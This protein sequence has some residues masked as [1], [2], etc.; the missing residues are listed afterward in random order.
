[1]LTVDNT[2]A[3][4]GMGCI[5][6]AGRNIADIVE[7]I[8]SGTRSPVISQRIHVNHP[9]KYP[10]FEM[11]ETVVP[12]GYYEAP[13]ASRCGILAI[14]ALQQALFAA[15]LDSK[16]LRNFRL[17]ICI[18]STVGN[19][20]NNEKFFADFLNSDYPDMEA[21]NDYLHASPA[22]M[23]AKYLGLN[24]LRQSVSNACASGAVAI[25]QGAKWLQNGLCDIVIAGGVDI[26]CRVI[27]N[28]FV[29]LKITDTEF[30]RPFDKNRAGLNLGE[31][32]GIVILET[33]QHARRRNS[34]NAGYVCGYGNFSDAYHMSAP[35]PDGMGLRYAID[36][37]LAQSSLSYDQITFINAH[38]TATSENDKVEGRLI[39]E[40]LPSVPFQSTKGYTGHT[41]GAAG[42]IEAILTIEQLNRQIMAASAGFNEPDDAFKAN[43]VIC[44]TTISGDYALSNSLAFGGNNAVLLLKRGS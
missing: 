37:A 35:V 34:I 5:C 20:M 6:A 39:S 38:G 33:I 9:Q 15:G 24:C 30:C 16:Q 14:E 7:A 8:Y 31:G 36:T 12:A 25:G 23:I 18:G 42:A 27:Y 44:N 13:E 29:S 1:M 41:L 26:L 28:G 43:P 40:L 32:A 19:A 21:I 4:T 3:I 10:V 11:S 2:I 22:D 17:G